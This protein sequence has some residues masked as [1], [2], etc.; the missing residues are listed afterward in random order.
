MTGSTNLSVT[1]SSMYR[2]TTKGG[3]MKQQGL[4]TA[5][6]RLPY[7]EVR[8]RQCMQNNRRL[9]ELGLTY[10]T[11][12][13]AERDLSDEEN[14]KGSKEKTRKK[15]KNQTSNLT[16]EVKFRCHKRVYVEQL[17][18]RSRKSKRS[19]SQTVEL[20]D[21]FE[22]HPQPAVED[23]GDAIPQG[24]G[25]NHRANRCDAIPRSDGHNHM[26]NEDGF[27]Q[28]DDN[29]TMH[30][31]ADVPA[32]ENERTNEGEEAPWNRGVNMGHGLQKMSR[33]HCGKLSVAITEGNIRPLVRL[34]APK[35]ATE[36]NIAIRNHVPVLTD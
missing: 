16:T 32:G 30:G 19:I 11:D 9:E 22:D 6:P 2:M 8:L 5:E 15:A 27:V 21:N 20:A 23:D 25:N 33:S 36:C 29:N 24:D 3:P 14:A 12:D 13:P 17:P 28:D 1:T 31:R 18:T 4:R 35:Y 34:I 26:A 10:T 7:E